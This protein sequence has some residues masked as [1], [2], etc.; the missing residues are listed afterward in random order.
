MAVLNPEHDPL[1]GSGCRKPCIAVRGPRV[2]IM[3]GRQRASGLLLGTA[4]N[5]RAGLADRVEGVFDDVVPGGSNDVEKQLTAK[6]R[7]TEAGANLAAIENDRTCF[8]S[9]AL[10]PFGED[11]AIACEQ[12][13]PTG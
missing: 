6:F 2:R 13:H 1:A 8:R 9:T 7:E 3:R 11:F 5:I 10:A 12:R 4:G